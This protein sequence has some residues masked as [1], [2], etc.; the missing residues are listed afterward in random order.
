MPPEE[1]SMT[2]SY[3]LGMAPVVSYTPWTITRLHARYSKDALG[4]DIVF[5]EVEPIVGGRESR[6]E[7]GAL[8]HGSVASSVNNFQGRYAIRHSW[9]GPI[10]CKEPHRG[11]WGGPWYDMQMGGGGGASAPVAA[12]KIAS[13]PRGGIPLT[14]FVRSDIPEIG[15]KAGSGPLPEIQPAAPAG[16]GQGAGQGAGGGGTGQG[17]APQ[18]PSGSRGCGGCVSAS[19]GP[20]D[21]GALFLGIGALFVA[22]SIARRRRGG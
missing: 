15:V 13:V 4:E 20:F 2:A 5:K 19:S 11:V 18:V 12:E 3:L 21:F 22:R 9:V 8:E 10:E 17:S 1:A 6:D 16:S 7:K 14:G